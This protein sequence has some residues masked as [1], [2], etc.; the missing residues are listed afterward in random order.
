[1]HSV[2]DAW[3]VTQFAELEMGLVV[4]VN[5]SSS[6]HSLYRLLQLDPVTRRGNCMYT[7]LGHAAQTEGL[8][9]PAIPINV[10]RQAALRR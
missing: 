1:M 3:K 10:V 7:Y 4:T 8:D 9:V 5:V 6:G 2:H